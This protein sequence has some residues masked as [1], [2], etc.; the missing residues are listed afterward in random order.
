MEDSLEEAEE[1]ELAA[2]L[3][4]AREVRQRERLGGGP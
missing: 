1:V 4:A 2:A 3:E